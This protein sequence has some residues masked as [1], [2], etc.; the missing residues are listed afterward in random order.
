MKELTIIECIGC[1]P[2]HVYCKPGTMVAKW[3]LTQGAR[4][5]GAFRAS[6]LAVACDY[7]IGSG[8]HN[9]AGK[10]Q[11]VAKWLARPFGLNKCQ[12]AVKDDSGVTAEDG[13]R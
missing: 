5:D 8:Y 9:A 12:E 1:Y 2:I 10:K 4:L 11:V 13:I 7:H 3:G 6:G